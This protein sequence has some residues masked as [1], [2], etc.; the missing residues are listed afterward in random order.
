MDKSF[1]LQETGRQAH[2]AIDQDGLLEL[3]LG[4]TLLSFALFLIDS[5]FLKT[6]LFFIWPI[7]LFILLPISRRY[8]TYPRVGYASFS[9]AKKKL[10]LVL[11]LIFNLV[12]LVLGIYVALTFDPGKRIPILD[13]IFGNFSIIIGLII[14]VVFLYKGRQ[15]GITRFYLYAFISVASGILNATISRADFP[16]TLGDTMIGYS[17]VVGIILLASGAN[18]FIRFLRKNPLPHRNLRDCK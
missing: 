15:S 5:L 10:L 11:L 4:L 13:L 16:D 14:A 9:P 2:R 18:T 12:F 1:D 3:Y 7:F 8:F 6:D 17:V